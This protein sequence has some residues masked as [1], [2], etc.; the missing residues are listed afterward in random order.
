MQDIIHTPTPA[1]RQGHGWSGCLLDGAGAA[2]SM[3]RFYCHGPRM[4]PDPVLVLLRRMCFLYRYRSHNRP[5]A[6]TV[7]ARHARD[8]LPPQTTSLCLISKGVE[9]EASPLARAPGTVPVLQPMSH[10]LRAMV[11][12]DAARQ[13][14]WW[15]RESGACSHR[16]AW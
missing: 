11:Y 5:I 6:Q 12:P 13:A 4:R 14:H 10:W 8:Y 15:Y 9:N 7:S 16:C 3:A 2:V 1:P